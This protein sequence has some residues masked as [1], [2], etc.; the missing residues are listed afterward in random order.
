[1]ERTLHKQK[2]LTL[3]G[4]LFVGVGLILVAVLLMKVVPVVFEYYTTVD[5]VKATASDPSL[6][7]A[8]MA[9]IRSA[10]QRRMMVADIDSVGAEDLEISKEGGQTVIAFEY[11]KK[12]HLVSNVSLF[13]EFS[14]SSAD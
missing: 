2:G 10:Y 6:N 11:E 1:M 9:Q 8:S 14:G 7:N 3:T 12:V 5:L 4:L 13:F